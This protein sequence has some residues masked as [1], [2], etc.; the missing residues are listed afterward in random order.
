ML[1]HR[2]RRADNVDVSLCAKAVKSSSELQKASKRITHF[3]LVLMLAKKSKL[4]LE[5]E[6]NQ[7]AVYFFVGMVAVI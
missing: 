3:R 1:G 7:S 5:Y 6:L 2:V 4:S